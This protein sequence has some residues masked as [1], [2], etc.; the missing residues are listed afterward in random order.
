MKTPLILMTLLAAAPMAQAQTRAVE[1][2]PVVQNPITY[3]AQTEA[4]LNGGST[5]LQAGT[6]PVIVNW[7]QPQALSNAA[8][9]RVTVADLDADGDGV[10]TRDEIPESHA[11][12]SEFRLVDSNRD[13]RITPEELANWR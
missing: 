7:G 13:G 6:G 1:T 9:Y 2:S 10:L 8:D 3:Q 4:R 11:L 12:Y 5:Q